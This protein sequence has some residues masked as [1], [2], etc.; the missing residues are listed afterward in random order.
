MRSQSWLCSFVVASGLVLAACGGGGGGTSVSVPVAKGEN[1]ATGLNPNPDGFAFPNFGASSSTEIFNEEDLVV[2]F[3]ATPE[4]CEG[5]VAEPCVPTAEAAAWAR[6]VNQAREAGHCEGFAVL[7]ASRFTANETP[8]TV[9]LLNQGDVTHGI[10]RAFATQ[11]LKETQ[12]STKSW[13]K[14][15]LRDIVATLENSFASGKVE[16]SL[17]VYSDLGGHAV[18]PYAVEYDS[19]DQARIK[20]YDSNWPGEERFVFVDLA[21]DEWRFSF[22]GSDPLTDPDAWVGGSGDLDITAMS[23][24]KSGTCPFCGDKSAVEKTLLIIRSLKPDWVLS[25]SGGEVTPQTGTVGEVS[26]K[27]LRS[28]APVTSNAAVD[29]IVEV[30]TSDVVDLEISS[31]TRVSGMTPTAAIEIDSPGDTGG[32]VSIEGKRITTE[33]PNIRLTMADG[34]LVASGQGSKTALSTTTDALQ[35]DITTQSGTTVGLSANSET[36]A[37]EVLDLGADNVDYE[38]VTQTGTQEI[39]RRT[40]AIDGAETSETSEGTVVGKTIANELPEVLKAPDVKP[41]LPPASERTIGGATSTTTSPATSVAPSSTTSTVVAPS[42]TAGANRPTQTTRPASATTSPATQTTQAQ[43]ASARKAAT[44][45]FNVDEW[46]AGVSDPIS[47]GFNARLSGG[48]GQ[49]DS[50]PACSDVACLESARAEI[51]GGGTDSASGGD[52]TVPVTFN[53]SGVSG[54]FSVRCGNGGWVSSSGSGSSQSASCTF[55]NVTSDVA[56]YIRA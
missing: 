38:V 47:S 48:A 43:N 45:T 3:G 2:M 36:P 53:M 40:V 52:V 54:A 30:P 17:G 19:P 46:S 7:S 44:V 56:V 8:K 42:T 23:A 10:M 26:V 24:R 31:P 5:G 12:D 13:A 11:F 49:L 22:F 18:L 6:M 34:D 15:S 50:A 39:T 28:S 41:G 55:A 33:S 35:V 25:T 27:P 32:S 29:F 1:A 9:D 20:M 51:L 16:Y 37:I 14:K 4:V 21:K